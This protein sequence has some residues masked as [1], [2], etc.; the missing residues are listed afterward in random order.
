MTFLLALRKDI[1]GRNDKIFSQNR[2]EV[3]TQSQSSPL[4]S[5]SILT[6]SFIIYIELKPII[7]YIGKAKT[8]LALKNG[9]TPT[10]FSILPNWR[11]ASFVLPTQQAWREETRSATGY[12]RG[13][14]LWH[15]ALAPSKYVYIYIYIFHKF[16]FLKSLS[17][18]VHWYWK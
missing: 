11:R 7:D 13:P 6:M 16:I 14:H 3:S 8:I 18:I 4:V 9:T 17:W 10:R 1:I 12:P 2:V 15:R 5:Q